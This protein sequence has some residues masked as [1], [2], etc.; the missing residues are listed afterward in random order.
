MT[1]QIPGYGKLNDL[2]EEIKIV[3]NVLEIERNS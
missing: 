3:P 1:L 2:L